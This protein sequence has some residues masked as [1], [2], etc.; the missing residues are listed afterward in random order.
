[1][2]QRVPAALQREADLAG[3]FDWQTHF[4]DGT[5][6]RAHQHAAGA[7]G[8]RHE[9][10]YVGPLLAAGAVR[11]ANRGRPRRRPECIVGDTGDSYAAVPRLLARTISRCSPGRRSL[12]ALLLWR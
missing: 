10:L 12:A 4:L 9:S 1:M 2:W 8:E 6:V 11:R 7:G 3:R 5:V